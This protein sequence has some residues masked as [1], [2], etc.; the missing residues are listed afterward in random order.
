M[1]GTQ[2][3]P[4]SLSYLDRIDRAFIRNKAQEG[5][6]GP[7]DKLLEPHRPMSTFL[8]GFSCDRRHSTRAAGVPLR[9]MTGELI[10]QLAGIARHGEQWDDDFYPRA[11]SRAALSSQP[12][13][14]RGGIC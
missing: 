8:H 12:I 9:L 1:M 13:L 2:N 6:S 4:A 14:M 11:F 5:D 3:R 10:D 7:Y